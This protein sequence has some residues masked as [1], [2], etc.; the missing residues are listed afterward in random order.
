MLPAAPPG[1][2]SSS[3]PE[4]VPAP[5][6]S[7]PPND[8]VLLA[9]PPTAA[10]ASVLRSLRAE[11][12]SVSPVSDGIGVLDA[13]R[14]RGPALLVLDVELPGPDQSAVLA[15]VQSEAP[16]VSVI[17]VTPRERRAGLLGLL[18]G[19]RDDYLLRP[20]AVDELAARIRLRLRLGAP[21]ENTV[22][23]QGELM[24]DT[25]FGEVSVDGR[26]V[27]LSPT[28]YAL[29]LALLATAGEVVAPDRLAKDVWS[30]P[31]SAN[32]VQVYISYL[33][34]KI[35][36]ERIRTVRGEGYVLEA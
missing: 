11:G 3:A 7:V 21:V 35:G 4:L 2:A 26:Q 12:V 19:D 30:E 33:R 17:A 28:E 23:R 24:V 5:R 20:F 13:V 25:E 8:H 6:A 32:L 29:L 10:S 27:S 16:N 14:A 31:A 34:R 1:G 36:P 15:A 9:L 18:R 22:L